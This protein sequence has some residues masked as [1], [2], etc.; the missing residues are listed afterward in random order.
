LQ[1]SKEA[2]GVLIGKRVGDILLAAKFDRSRHAGSGYGPAGESRRKAGPEGGE[3][4]VEAAAAGIVGQQHGPTAKLGRQVPA[5]RP[6]GRQ[7]IEVH[8]RVI[9]AVQV[10]HQVGIGRQAGQRQAQPVQ[11]RAC[12]APGQQLVDRLADGGDVGCRVVAQP[13]GDLGAERREDVGPI[14]VEVAAA[15]QLEAA[16]YALVD[17]LIEADRVGVG[18]EDDLAGDLAV[19]SGLIEQPH[20]MMLDQQA[21]GLVGVQRGLQ[22]G[23]GAG[24]RG[25]IA[26]DSE[27]SFRARPV[28]AEGDAIALP[29]HG[30]VRRFM[31]SPIVLLGPACHL[32][33]SEGRSIETQRLAVSVL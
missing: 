30:F 28:G 25:A 26:M 22:I 7:Q 20:E 8:E 18:H 3:T 21:G 27:E 9:V 31:V 4:L 11:F 14:A 2:P 33:L 23:L 29:F 16:G 15:G 13:I 32:K 17:D 6:M 5:F 19:C 10:E 1:R 12:R 24:V